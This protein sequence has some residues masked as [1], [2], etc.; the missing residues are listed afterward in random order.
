MTSSASLRS[1]MQPR[2]CSGL[3]KLVERIRRRSKIEGGD[4]EEEEEEEES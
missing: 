4:E 3:T 1:G 2:R